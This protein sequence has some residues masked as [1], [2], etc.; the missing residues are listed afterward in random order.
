LYGFGKGEYPGND[1]VKGWGGQEELVVFLG[2]DAT[3]GDLK[4]YGGQVGR[5]WERRC[6]GG[7]GWVGWGFSSFAR[8]EFRKTISE[9]RNA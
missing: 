6:L 4:F 8:L 9:I 2:E 1:E 5:W 3:L 7:F